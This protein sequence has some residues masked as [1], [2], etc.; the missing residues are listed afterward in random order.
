V[1]ER[2]EEPTGVGCVLHVRVNRWKLNKKTGRAGRAGVSSDA[3]CVFVVPD[4]DVKKHCLFCMLAE[5]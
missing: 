2:G 1:C 3:C 5:A 4:V